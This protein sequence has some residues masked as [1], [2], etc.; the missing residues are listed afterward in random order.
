[1]PHKNTPLLP[2]CI[3]TNPNNWVPTTRTPW[4]GHAIAGIKKQHRL[5]ADTSNQ[6]FPHI[7]PT[8]TQLPTNIGE[9]WEISIDPQF[10]S[11]VTRT[12]YTTPTL[13]S[14]LIA[15][16]TPQVMGNATVISDKTPVSGFPLLLKW[17]HAHSFLSVQIHPT[18]K[19]VS[20]TPG[21]SGKT[22][23]WYVASASDDAM[24]Y[25]GFKSGTTPQCVET[26]MKHGTVDQLLNAIPVKTGDW[27]QIPF[28]CIH[29]L[30]PNIFVIEP[31]EV[32]PNTQGITYRFFDWNK[33]Y[34]ASGELDPQGSLR[35]LHIVESVASIDWSLPQGIEFNHAFVNS[36]TRHTPFICMPITERTAP[37]PKQG[38]PSVLS[39]WQ[40]G[41]Q[42]T[43]TDTN[44]TTV[45]EMGESALIPA[46]YSNSIIVQGIGGT[47]PGTNQV[48]GVLFVYDP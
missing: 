3:K 47:V 14:D 38:L 1:M 8:P 36:S 17:I 22:E 25:A 16:H 34:N 33:K 9:T 6:A 41:V 39:V 5:F 2:F 40:G 46:C 12:G 20:A 15:N 10:P 7:Q 27:I 31:Q 42:V 23:A 35:P 32:L 29:A 21:V 44:L 26:A 4:A 48:Y 43:N 13:L 11:Y 28:G 19:A 45:V 37:L 24:I 30:G 18:H